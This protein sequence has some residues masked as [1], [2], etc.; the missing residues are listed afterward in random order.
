[1]KLYEYA[2]NILAP[3][4]IP[5]AK[6]EI[7]LNLIK[8]YNFREAIDVLHSCVN[9][10][11]EPP[12]TDTDSMISLIVEIEKHICMFNDDFEADDIIYND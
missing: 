6:K 5:I 7:I 4:D 11:K 2:N 9:I 8:N 10:N 1:M 12:L 3:L